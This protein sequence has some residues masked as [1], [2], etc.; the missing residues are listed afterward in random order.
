MTDI[1]RL[2]AEIDKRKTAKTKAQVLVEQ[3]ETKWLADYETKEPEEIQT[4]H[5]NL[6]AK[7]V[8]LKA[9]REELMSEANKLLG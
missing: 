1:E 2:E 6:K 5:N 8:K 9:E 4:I 3:I 7:V